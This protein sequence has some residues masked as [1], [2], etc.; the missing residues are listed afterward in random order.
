MRSNSWWMDSV[1]AGLPDLDCPGGAD[2][3]PESGMTG[4]AP[5]SRQLRRSPTS[6]R[7]SRSQVEAAELVRALIMRKRS[8]VSLS[9]RFSINTFA[10]PGVPN[11]HQNGRISLLASIA[12]SSR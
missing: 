6:G 5:E 11:L 2:S 12:T 1:N 4:S 3:C 8:V 10:A 7:L 9:M